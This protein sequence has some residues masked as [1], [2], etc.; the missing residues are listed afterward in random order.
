VPDR[1]QLEQ[2]ART[3]LRAALALAILP[4]P[5]A[6]LAPALEGFVPTPEFREI[7]EA[8]MLLAA[9]ALGTAQPGDF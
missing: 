2:R 1:R 8:Q 7:A 3:E 6:A 9:L 4:T 5:D